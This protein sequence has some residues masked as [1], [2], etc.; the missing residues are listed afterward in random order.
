MKPWREYIEQAER[1]LVLARN[2]DDVPK[3][4]AD[5]LYQVMVAVTQ[6]VMEL[7]KEKEYEATQSGREHDAKT[8]PGE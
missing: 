8:R 5:C 4:A 6:A 2:R 7:E 3:R 1:L